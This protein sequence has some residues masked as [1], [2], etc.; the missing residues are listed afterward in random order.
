[1][2]FRVNASASPSSSA[3]T[4]RVVLL[5]APRGFRQRQQLRGKPSHS[6]RDR[7]RERGPGSGLWRG[8]LDREGN[9]GGL[10]FGRVI[11]FAAIFDDLKLNGKV[12]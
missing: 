7:G 2:A 8:P 9:F 12:V 1:M 11:E 5:R 10:G 3:S 6:R 4:A